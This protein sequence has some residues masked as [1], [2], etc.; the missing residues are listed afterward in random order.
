MTEW[1]GRRGKGKG[2]EIKERMLWETAMKIVAR[3]RT[4]DLCIFK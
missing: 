3:E 2:G 4:M 1:V